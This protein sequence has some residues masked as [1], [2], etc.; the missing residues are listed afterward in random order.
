[1]FAL[2]SLDGRTVLI[3]EDDAA[4][5]LDLRLALIDAGAVVVGPANS[6]E[7]AFALMADHTLDAAVLDVR[8][9]NDE[10]VFGL[11]DAL[12]ALRIPFIFASGRSTA[13]MPPKHRERPFLDKPFLAMDLVNLL[14]GLLK[15]SDAKSD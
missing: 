5:A 4:I 3:V 1:V 13:L 14:V 15:D 9:K 11:A 6:V 7:A 8:L 12:D 2:E 10:L